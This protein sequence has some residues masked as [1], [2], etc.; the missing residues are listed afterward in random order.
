MGGGLVRVVKT[1][2][3]IFFVLP[4]RTRLCSSYGAA[5]QVRLAYFRAMQCFA[6]NLAPLYANAE[7]L[8]T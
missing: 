1:L 8:L 6:G 7:S 5:L 3:R 2:V 4:F